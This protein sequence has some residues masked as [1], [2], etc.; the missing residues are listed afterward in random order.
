MALGGDW[1][2]NAKQI[3]LYKYWFFLFVHVK[4]GKKV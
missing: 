4:V 1:S 3:T 2:M